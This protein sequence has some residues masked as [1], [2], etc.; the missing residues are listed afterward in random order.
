MTRGDVGSASRTSERLSAVACAC[1][2]V[3][4][5]IPV[6][7]VVDA[8][9]VGGF[10]VGGP[11]L[12]WRCGSS[13]W[14]RTVSESLWHQPERVTLS[15]LHEWL[16]VAAARAEGVRATYRPNPKLVP[17]LLCK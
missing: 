2:L 5:D 17:R 6:V 14:S 1:R 8:R 13:S 12:A 16:P 3:D 10:L 15:C 9:Q 11:L 7:G 4:A